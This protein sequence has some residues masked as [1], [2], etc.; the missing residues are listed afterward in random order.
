MLYSLLYNFVFFYRRIRVKYKLKIIEDAAEALGSKYKNKHLG[1]F[2]DVGCLSFNGNKIVTTGAGGAI[3]TNNK[4]FF[5][6]IYH[7]ANVAKVKHNYDLEHDKIGYNYL[8]K[9]KI[10][11]T[12]IF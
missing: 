11:I 12:I 1:L 6:K 3:I 10:F 9:C 4:N 8:W 2:G 7:Y 5:K